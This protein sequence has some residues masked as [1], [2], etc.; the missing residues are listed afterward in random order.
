MCQNALGGRGSFSALPDFPAAIGGGCLLL[1]GK[2]RKGRY[3]AE[4][5][6]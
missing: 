5:R 3:E 4:G 6:E 1:T 2:G